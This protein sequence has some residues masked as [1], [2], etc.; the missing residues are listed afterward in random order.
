MPLQKDFVVDVPVAWMRPAGQAQGIVIHTPAFGQTKEDAAPVLE[1]IAASGR[2]GV[3]LDAH[4][5]GERGRE[6]RDALFARVFRNFRTHMWTILGETA[7][8]VPAVIDWALAKFGALPVQLSGLSMGG[9]VA[10]VAMG[11]DARPVR[12]NVVVATPDW[13]RPGMQAIRSGELV[14]Q[15]AP[16]LRAKLL[17]EALDPLTHAGRYVGREIHFVCGAEDHHVPPEAAFR[18][19]DRVGPPEA[20]VITIELLPGKSHLDF[21]DPAL[22]WPHVRLDGQQS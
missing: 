4:Q 20:R 5:H 9:D 13:T 11:I 2:V 12:A 8:D 19:A 1:R 14:D 3:A 16:D 6:S 7:L 17:Y 21:I 15:G 18:F 22:W 10:V